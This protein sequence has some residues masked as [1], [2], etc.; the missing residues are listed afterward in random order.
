MPITHTS[1]TVS[2][3]EESTRF[4]LRALEPL[5]YHFVE[6][7]AG[8]IGFGVDEADFFLQQQTSGYCR[9]LSQD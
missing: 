9:V 1:L 6:T 5:G 7:W 2:N 3:I 4:F 8:Q